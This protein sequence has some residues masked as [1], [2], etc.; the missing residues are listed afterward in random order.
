MYGS[1]SIP[2]LCV[3][4]NLLQKSPIS[5]GLF[6]KRDLILQGAISLW[7]GLDESPHSNIKSLLQKSP[8]K[9]GHFLKK[10]LTKKT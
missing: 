4:R 1:L 5:V 7:R 8:L 9:I 2:C 6:R 3:A 10:D